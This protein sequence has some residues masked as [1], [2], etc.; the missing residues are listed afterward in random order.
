MA[1]RDL[2]T[3][4]AP[5]VSVGELSRYWR[6]SR[7]QIRKYIEAGTLIAIRLGPR[8]FRIS[9]PVAREFEKRARLPP[10]LV[11]VPRRGA[12]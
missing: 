4:T 8:L 2:S 3:H 12:G 5:Y 1:I 10:N 7:K 6:I 11:H 9:T